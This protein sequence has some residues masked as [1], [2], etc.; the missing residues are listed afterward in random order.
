M[1]RWVTANERDMRHISSVCIAD[2]APTLIA[3]RLYNFLSDRY[4]QVVIDD[5]G[6]PSWPGLSTSILQEP[7]ALCQLIIKEVKFGTTTPTRS[8]RRFLIH[9]KFIEHPCCFKCSFYKQFWMSVGVM[10]CKKC[11]DFDGSSTFLHVMRAFIFLSTI[12]LLQPV[13]FKTFFLATSHDTTGFDNFCGMI[14]LCN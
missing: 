11:Y 6:H 3:L 2:N 7:F 5:D 1:T 10:S 14:E 12:F 9:I 4:F 13:T 8:H